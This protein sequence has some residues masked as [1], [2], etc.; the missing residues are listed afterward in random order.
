MILDDY[1]R[2]FDIRNPVVL[3]ETTDGRVLASQTDLARIGVLL[4]RPTDVAAVEAVVP[5]YVSTPD[6]PM[7]ETGLLVGD[8]VQ[9]RGMRRSIADD[10]TE[11]LITLDTTSHLLFS[12]L[13]NLPE[14]PFRADDWLSMVRTQLTGGS[15]T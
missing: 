7:M 11:R 13:A 8:G 1:T 3:Y 10:G 4:V 14:C 9:T 6:L 2:F 12:R 15:T 5:V